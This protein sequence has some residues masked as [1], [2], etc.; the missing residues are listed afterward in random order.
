MKAERDRRDIGSAV[1]DGSATSRIK[2]DSDMRIDHLKIRSLIAHSPSLGLH[3]R[4][5]PWYNIGVCG[6]NSSHTGFNYCG[7]S[8]G[9]PGTKE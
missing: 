5:M 4:V 2:C 1:E 8:S 6:A 9:I 3:I 7:G